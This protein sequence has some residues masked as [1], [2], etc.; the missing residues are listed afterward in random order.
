LLGA[1]LLLAAACGGDEVE[2][3]T[4]T[5][6]VPAEGPLGTLSTVE[7]AR[8]CEQTLAWAARAHGFERLRDPLCRRWAASAAVLM[9]S[10]TDAA[11]MTACQT[12]YDHCVALQMLNLGPAPACPTA[13]SS[14]TA[15]VR[16]LVVC[17][18]DLEAAYHV[19][20]AEVRPCRELTRFGPAEVP[21]MTATIPASCQALHMACPEVD[22]PWPPGL[23]WAP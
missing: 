5:T 15:P 6:D 19:A 17:L 1:W 11:L 10:T 2:D 22:L 3:L 13:N 4:F 9:A 12:S 14:C 18:N 16:Q 20:L 7:A 21:K 8:L 23:G